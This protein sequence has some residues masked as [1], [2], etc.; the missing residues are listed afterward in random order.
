L[1]IFAPFLTIVT[2]IF[3]PFLTFFAAIFTPFHSGRLS[4]YL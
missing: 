3:A 4:L 2:P 1:S